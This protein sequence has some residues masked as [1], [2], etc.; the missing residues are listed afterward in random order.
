MKT[1]KFLLAIIY[2][3]KE[4]VD[5]EVKSMYCR[6]LGEVLHIISKMKNLYSS[7]EMERVILELRNLFIP[8]SSPSATSNNLLFPCK[9]RLADF[10]SVL[11]H[12]EL[13]DSEDDPKSSVV[14]DLYHVLLRE[15]HWAFAHLAVAA[16][17]YFAARTCCNELWRFV[18]P[19]AALSFDLETGN[20][21]DEDRFMSK[22]KEFLEKESA[23]LVKNHTSDHLQMLIKEGKTLKEVIQHK[24][25]NKPAGG[26][27][28]NA[29][30]IDEVNPVNKK[31]K[32]PHRITKGVELLQSGIK[33]MGD[34]LSQW[35]H[36]P[37][38]FSS[39]EIQ[40]EF[41]SHFS[42]LEDVVAH[43]VSLAKSS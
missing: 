16:F 19:D 26:V 29:M 21:A 34:G 11:G 37:F 30:E 6:L 13:A 9:P 43:L 27:V 31:R 8:K 1:L 2:K 5:K 33:V 17:G 25:K 32:L 7:D 40:D 28:C 15:R 24:L 41:L 38:S 23:S 42:R 39:T 35:Q 20:E 12:V 36:N 4:S 18:P 3:Y 22:L 14:W 10:M